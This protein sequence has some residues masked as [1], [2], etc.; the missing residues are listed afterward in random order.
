M[1]ALPSKADIQ[2]RTWDVRFGPETDFMHCNKIME[3]DGLP[4]P[5]SAQAALGKSKVSSRTA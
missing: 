3:T 5:L 1:S 4:S 2:S